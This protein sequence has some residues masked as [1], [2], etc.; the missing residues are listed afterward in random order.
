MAAALTGEA[1]AA[2]VRRR[3]E[4]LEEYARQMERLQNEI[5]AAENACSPGSQ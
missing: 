5:A 3:E 2:K 4:M 1:L